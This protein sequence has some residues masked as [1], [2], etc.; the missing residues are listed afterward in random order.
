MRFLPS[1]VITGYR[2]TTGV[3]YVWCRH[4]I[5]VVLQFSAECNILYI[6]I[7][8][9]SVSPGLNEVR[10]AHDDEQQSARPGA[11]RKTRVVRRAP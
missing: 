6:Y 8:I 4:G 1:V 10:G 7:N 3:A 5:G 11:R 9:Y 2:C